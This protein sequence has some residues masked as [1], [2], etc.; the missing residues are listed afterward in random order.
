MTVKLL[1][2][3]CRSQD[4]TVHRTLTPTTQ[5]SRPYDEDTLTSRRVVG[6]DHLNTLISADNFAVDLHAA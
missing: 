5:R 2:R 6:N 4:P 3:S 1:P